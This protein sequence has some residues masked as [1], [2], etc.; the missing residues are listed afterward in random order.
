MINLTP[1]VGARW[2]T[3]PKVNQPSEEEDSSN[4][5]EWENNGALLYS[6]QHSKLHADGE[7]GLIVILLR[8]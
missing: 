4:E 1:F 5:C 2:S 3:S 8:E 7:D 6:L